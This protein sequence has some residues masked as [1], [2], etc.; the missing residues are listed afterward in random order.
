MCLC[1]ICGVERRRL[2]D[3]LGDVGDRLAVEN[4]ILQPDVSICSLAG[5]VWRRTQLVYGSRN[6]Q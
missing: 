2:E 1:G 6:L 5:C 4:I 3:L